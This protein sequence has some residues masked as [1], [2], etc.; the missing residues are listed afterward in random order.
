MMCVCVRWGVGGWGEFRKVDSKVTPIGRV[1]SDARL[2][3][4]ILSR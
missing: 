3:D 1:K 2:T 4:M